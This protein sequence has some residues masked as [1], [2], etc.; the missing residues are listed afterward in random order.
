MKNFKR[1]VKN[2]ITPVTVLVCSAFCLLF[3]PVT[4]YAA[5][6]WMEPYEQFEVDNIFDLMPRLKEVGIIEMSL[7]PTVY[8]KRGT[9]VELSKFDPIFIALSNGANVKYL[10]RIDDSSSSKDTFTYYDLT[11]TFIGDRTRDAMFRVSSRWVQRRAADGSFVSKGTA[12]DCEIFVKSGSTG[13]LHDRKCIKID[14]GVPY[15]LELNPDYVCISES[16]YN[17]TFGDIEGTYDLSLKN[18]L[19]RK[20]SDI[21]L[22]MKKSGKSWI[23]TITGDDGIVSASH[24]VKGTFSNESG[25]FYGQAADG[26]AIYF[27]MDMKGQ[28]EIKSGTWTLRDSARNT[29]ESWSFGPNYELVVT[30]NQ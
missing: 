21:T 25:A 1:F 8:N 28:P 19:G 30:A 4:A 27:T 15:T 24:R 26:T 18:S 23:A 2:R 6:H 22:S 9:V 12:E 5:D 29:L 13:I 16:D 20:V 10:M 14:C 7:T 3:T 17:D 11:L